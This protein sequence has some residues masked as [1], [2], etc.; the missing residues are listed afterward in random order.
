MI[1]LL[2]DVGFPADCV[3]TVGNQYTGARTA[4]IT[5]AGLTGDIPIGRGNTSRATH[6]PR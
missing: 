1:A 6:Y 3:N 4:L 5:P 2:E